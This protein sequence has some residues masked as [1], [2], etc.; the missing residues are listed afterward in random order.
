LGIGFKAGYSWTD[1]EILNDRNGKPEIIVSSTIEKLFS[2]E[3]NPLRF[4][5]SMSHCR[6]HATATVIRTS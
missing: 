5:L 3:G 4:L 2:K 6:E 1:I